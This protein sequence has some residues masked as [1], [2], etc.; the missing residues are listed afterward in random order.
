MVLKV[1]SPYLR[2]CIFHYFLQLCHYTTYWVLIIPYSLHASVSFHLVQRGKS[3]I[4]KNSFL[5]SLTAFP[6]SHPSTSVTSVGFLSSIFVN[7]F[8]TMSKEEHSCFHPNSWL[9]LERI[10]PADEKEAY[11]QLCL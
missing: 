8:R 7:H 10:L 3:E 5:F 6:A 4:L 9:R 2:R 1:M 11:F